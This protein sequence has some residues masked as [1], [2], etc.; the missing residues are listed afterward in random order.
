MHSTRFL[1]N[2]QTRLLWIGVRVVMCHFGHFKFPAKGKIIVLGHCKLEYWLWLLLCPLKTLGS[3]AEYCSTSSGL[4]TSNTEVEC[5][6][7]LSAH[8]VWAF[9]LVC[10]SP[11]LE[12][13]L[14]EGSQSV[15]WGHAC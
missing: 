8:S 3:A 1:L 7:C 13:Q 6:L 12:K 10:L 14:R 9:V 15:S 11:I 5:A 4:G 2:Q